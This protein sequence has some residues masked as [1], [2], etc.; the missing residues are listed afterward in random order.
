MCVRLE[1]LTYV[2][3]C[4]PVLREEPNHEDD[5]SAHCRQKTF[6]VGYRCGDRE[7]KRFGER[8]YPDDEDERRHVRLQ[9]SSAMDE[10]ARC[11]RRFISGVDVPTTLP[12]T[13]IGRGQFGLGFMDSKSAGELRD[14]AEANG[15]FIESLIKPPQDK[16]DL[17]RFEAKIKTAR[18]IGAKAARTVIIPSRRYEYFKIFAE[19]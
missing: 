10:V 6:C 14:Y 19:F 2:A 13:R 3:G 18:D 7:S 16:G 9:H 8:A 5:Q 12:L 11:I 15:L 4:Q 1:S 17:P